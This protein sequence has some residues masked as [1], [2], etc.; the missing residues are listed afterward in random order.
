ME[1]KFISFVI[2]VGA[3]IMGLII[4]FINSSSG[5]KVTNANNVNI[6]DG[7]Q[8][9]TIDVGGGYN[10]KKSVAKSNIPTIIKFNTDGAFDCSSSVRI[11]SL[12]ISKILPQTGIT[13]VDI[14]SPNAGTL[15]GLCSMG[16][17]RFQ[18]DFK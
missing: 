8:I 6:V 5:G 18:I 9:I 2:I 15:N 7:K 11:P 12:N 3:I 13:D 16:M 17:Y 1:K 14:G 4:I 10:P